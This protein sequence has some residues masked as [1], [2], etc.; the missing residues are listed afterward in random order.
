MNFMKKTAKPPTA[1]ARNLSQSL[2][3]LKQRILNN[4]AQP[5]HSEGIGD[6]SR[7]HNNT[8]EQNG[9]IIAQNQLQG[10]QQYQQQFQTID[11]PQ[12]VLSLLKPAIENETSLKITANRGDELFQTQLLDIDFSRKVLRLKKIAYT[13]GHFMVIGAKYLTVYSQHDGAQ[14]SFRTYLIRYSERNGGYYEIRFPEQVKYC[15]RRLSHRVHLSFALNVKAEF[16]DE[17]GEKIQGHLRD[18][19][20]DGV[21]LQ[22]PEVDPNNLHTKSLIKDCVINF[23]DRE[24]I[25]CNLQIQHKYNHL[26]KKG[27]TIGG[28]FY[29]M[30]AE[31]KK[32]IQKLIT[33]LERRLLREVRI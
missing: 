30:N 17:T 15:Q 7:M 12:R 8:I 5:E 31:Q 1:E 6:Q 10:E 14:I 33:G 21:R 27:C 24:Q 19:S 2:N 16:Y 26:R 28:A 18:I 29:E 22:L 4:R 3:A 9:E 20:A 23:P 11:D 32:E 13:Y 25:H